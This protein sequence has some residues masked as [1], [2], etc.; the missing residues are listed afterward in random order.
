MDIF[1]EE[2]VLDYENAEGEDIKGAA[3]KFFSDL[4]KIKV[5]I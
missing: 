5:G 3:I 4:W 2:I 1:G